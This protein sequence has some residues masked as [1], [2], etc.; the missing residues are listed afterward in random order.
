MTQDK[1]WPQMDKQGLPPIGRPLISP[2]WLWTGAKNLAGYGV[3]GWNGKFMFAHRLAYQFAVGPIPA[4][5]Y[6]CH[7]CD[8]P[9]CCNPLHL[10]ADTPRGN[11]D[12][13]DKKGRTSKGEKHSV[14]VL[15]NRPRGDGHYAA[16][17]DLRKVIE[18][19]K[20]HSESRATYKEIGDEFG[21]SGDTAEKAITGQTWKHVTEQ[22]S[23]VNNG[24]GDTHRF[25]KL[26]STDVLEIRRIRRETSASYGNLSAM[27][28][29]APRTIADVITRKSWDHV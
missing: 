24:R 5:L 25:A 13:R 29:V 1:F 19:R 17:L 12:D 27:F 11:S 15:P 18:M 26:T 7:D 21:V 20:R 3:T 6:I 23:M 8:T 2:C 9:L 28:G 4:G 14:A 16:K 22:L 10:F